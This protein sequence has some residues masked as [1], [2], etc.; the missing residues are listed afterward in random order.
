MKISTSPD[1]GS[2]LKVWPSVGGPGV[3]PM[4]V[5]NVTSWPKVVPALFVA[6][7]RTW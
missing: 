2:I 6:T 4:A 3:G 1:T 5:V 7:N